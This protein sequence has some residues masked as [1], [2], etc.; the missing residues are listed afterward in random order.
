[1]I[2]SYNKINRSK[3]NVRLVKNILLTLKLLTEKFSQLKNINFFNKI[4]FLLIGMIP[5][6]LDYM[7]NKTT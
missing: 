7:F 2:K 5:T 1:M 3:K 6:I 4:L